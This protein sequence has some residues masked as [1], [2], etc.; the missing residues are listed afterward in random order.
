MFQRVDTPVDSKT[1]TKCGKALPSTA[2]LFSECAECLWEQALQSTEASLDETAACRGPSRKAD[3]DVF[4]TAHRRHYGKP[5]KNILERMRRRFA[6]KAWGRHPLAQTEAGYIGFAAQMGKRSARR[7]G[8]EG[9]HTSEDVQR[10]YDVQ[11]GRCFYCG[12]ELNGRYDL[13]RKIPLSRGGTDWPENLCCACE[14]CQCGKC[15]MTAEEFRMYLI[16]LRRRP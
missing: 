11:G 16:N 9:S 4:R 7:H 2:E 3:P 5:H 13:D 15:D 14:V 8:A 12:K 1:C 10:L 6:A